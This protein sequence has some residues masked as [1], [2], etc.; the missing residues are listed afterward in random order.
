MS[1]E[2][3][4][5]RAI[6]RRL[7]IEPHKLAMAIF[8][9]S[10]T[11]FFA[12]LI[13][14]FIS[15]RAGPG[16]GA[17]SQL[18]VPLTAMFT[19][20][21]IASSGTIVLAERRLEHGDMRGLRLWLMI[22]VLLGAVFLLGQTFEYRALLADGVDLGAGIWA[23]AFYTLTGFHGLHVL[24]GLVTLLVVWSVA[25]SPIFVRRARD[26]FEPVSIYWHFVDVVWIVVFSVV[27]LWSAA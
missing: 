23:S 9:M 5:L 4:P 13:I 24:G 15:H 26:V 8:V 21:L 22:T 16:S 2:A 20:A 11:I 3:R 6:E 1:S 12:S 27:Y 7:E 17:A 25:D 19:A 14:T 18:N 10:E